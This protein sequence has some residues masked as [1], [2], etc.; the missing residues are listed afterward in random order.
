MAC[1]VVLEGRPLISTDAAI[2]AHI[3]LAPTPAAARQG[4]MFVRQQ[5][6][7]VL[8]SRA[9]DDVLLLTSELVTNGLLHARTELHLGVTYDE[10]NVLVTLLDRSAALP[11]PR[12][13]DAD[14]LVHL[15]ESGRGMAL[16]ASIADD[17]GWR[18]LPTT[19]GKVV[20][21]MMSADRQG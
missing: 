6:E 5:L 20:W 1:G 18:R 7:T 11:P 12:P 14:G 16:M 8:T 13:R 9:L 19:Q 2:S 4:R 15:A 10:E 3:D 17:F 21:F